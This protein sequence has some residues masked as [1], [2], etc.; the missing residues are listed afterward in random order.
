[1][2]GLASQT[3]LHFVRRGITELWAEMGVPFKKKGQKLKMECHPSCKH[4]IPSQTFLQPG[5]FT[6][7]AQGINVFSV[8]DLSQSV[9][10]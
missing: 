7:L 9:L 6:S 5:N 1:M 8:L 4:W 10:A 3:N 2:R